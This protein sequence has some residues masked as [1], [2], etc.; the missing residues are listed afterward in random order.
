VLL[1]AVAAL[2]STGCLFDPK[3][4]EG[5]GEDDGG[6]YLPP[7]SPENVLANLATAYRFKEIDPYDRVTHDDFVFKPSLDDD[8]ITFT[9]LNE[10]DDFHSTKNMFTDVISI[11]INLESS[12]PTPSDLPLYPASE[13]YLRVLVP[14]VFISVET[15][16]D[17]EMWTLK[18]EGD[19]AKFIF[20]PDF[21]VSPTTYSIIYQQDLHIAAREVQEALAQIKAKRD[22]KG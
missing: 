7:T 22:T 3:T 5:P 19:P 11:D 12:G 14:Q 18:V 13:G 10:R 6:S 15:Q 9:E 16:I 8:E 2:L 17:G 1:P 20:A 4:K 21:S